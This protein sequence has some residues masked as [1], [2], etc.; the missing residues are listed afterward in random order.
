MCL[1]SGRVIL[2]SIAVAYRDRFVL[3]FS[4]KCN[5]LTIFD[6]IRQ[7]SD[8]WSHDSGLHPGF[9]WIDHPGTNQLY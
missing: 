5:D 9:L 8:W 2:A 7:V 4:L 3:N 1:S 6:N